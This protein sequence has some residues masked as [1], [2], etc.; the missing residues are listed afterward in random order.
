MMG[1]ETAF[2]FFQYTLFFSGLPA[3]NFDR[4]P[5]FEYTEIHSINWKVPAMTSTLP[6]SPVARFS[7]KDQL[8]NSTKIEALA[9]RLRAVYPH[10]QAQAF[11]QACVEGFPERELKARIGWIRAQLRA[12]L[13]QDYRTAVAILLKALPEP[14]NPDLSD[15]D[16]GDFIYAPF[17]DF[18][19]VYGC[20][21]ADLVF[22]LSA[23]QT[24]TTRFSAE[25]AI[26]AFIKAFPAE[27]LATLADWSQAE[28]YH[29]RRLVSEGT[30]PKLPW[31]QAIP[32]RW[33]Q[34]EPL[35][36]RLYTDPTRF[37]T[38][39]VA[40]HL[41]DW[42][43]SHPKQVI[44]TLKRWQQQAKQAPAE[45]AFITRHALR[46]LSRQGQTEAL[47]LLGFAPATLELNDWWHSPQ[48]KL[49]EALAFEFTLSVAQDTELMIDYQMGFQA[50]KGGPLRLKV[51]K[52]KQLKLKA[53]EPVAL[54]KRHVLKAMTT[55]ALYPGT[56]SLA[57]QI[58]GRVFPAQTFELV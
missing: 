58:N 25:D 47:A 50:A 57:L 21:S 37:V 2:V 41:N 49:G 51:F 19:A 39:S 7:L 4:T 35:L 9:G 26:R 32:I 11:T 14:C 16:F 13:P 22:S 18:V 46:T 29:V 53:G 33:E 44:A 15:D 43:K 24:I 40:N 27:T 10:F 6:K 38:R 30:R 5:A 31:A 17:S 45:M 20:T 48:V 55:R 1:C 34:A 36:S 28:H 12:F 52:L 3:E 56:H 23:I 8:F 54:S 42:S